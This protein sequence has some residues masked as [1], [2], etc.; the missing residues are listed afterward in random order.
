M[1]AFQKSIYLNACVYSHLN[2]CSPH[3][4]F[5]RMLGKYSSSPQDFKVLKEFSIHKLNN[6]MNMLNLF[7]VLYTIFYIYCIY[8]IYFIYLRQV[9]LKLNKGKSLCK[10]RSSNLNVESCQ[11]PPNTIEK[12]QVKMVGPLRKNIF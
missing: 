8:F 12:P 4:N 5:R 10:F 7:F 6:N 11:N 1:N 9:F 3:R 2:V